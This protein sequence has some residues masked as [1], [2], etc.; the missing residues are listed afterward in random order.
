MLSS[1]IGTTSALWDAQVPALESGFRVVRYDHPGHGTLRSPGEP[2]RS[3][4]WRAESSTSSTESTSHGSRSAGS[5]SAAWSA[6]RSRSTRRS[7]S[8]G[9][10]SAAP[11]RTSGRPR[12]GTSVPRIV[13]AERHRRDRGR[14]C[15]SAGSRSDSA[16]SRP[17]GGALPR[18]ARADPREGYAALL[19]GDR[20]LGRTH[21]LDAI[22]RADA[23]DRRAPTTSRRRPRTERFLAESIP[24]AE[25]D[26]PARGRPSRERRAAR[27]RSTERSS[28]T[29]HRHRGGA[30]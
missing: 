29:L 20:A 19:R 27:A 14:A 21:E 1:S 11:R 3:N 10:S 5:R 30:A 17:T 15:S 26:G 8:T 2:S 18:D 25:L 7:A 22:T 4:R 24:G 6:W 12:A 16:T 23:R 9:S 28:A 13:R